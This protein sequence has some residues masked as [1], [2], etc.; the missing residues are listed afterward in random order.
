MKSSF[1]RRFATRW[2]HAGIELLPEPE[3]RAED[4]RRLERR[5]PEGAGEIARR[6]PRAP[7][8]STSSGTT[9]RSCASSTP[10][11]SRPCG[12]SSLHALGQQAHDDR[13]RGHRQRGAERERALPAAAGGGEQRGEERGG[14]HHLQPAEPEHQAAHL[15]ELRQAELEADGE[16]Q[17][18]HAELGEIGGVSRSSAIQPR[19]CGPSATPIIR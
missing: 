3:N 1:E 17:E 10:M 6:R 4:R 12:V 19:A 16:H 9:A 2:N 14:E 11:T 8:T 18:H 13:G 5:E 15:R 7:G